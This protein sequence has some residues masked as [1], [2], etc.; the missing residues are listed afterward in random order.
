MLGGEGELGFA[1]REARE[2]D[3]AFTTIVRGP[4]GRV[5]GYT[6]YRRADPRDPQI[7]TPPPL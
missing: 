5:K 1:A 2:L 3:G 6:T 4:D 7:P